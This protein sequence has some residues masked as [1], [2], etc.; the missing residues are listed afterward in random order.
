MLPWLT[1]RNALAVL[2]AILFLV[3]WNQGVALLYGMFALV[4]ATLVMAWI[5]PKLVLRDVHVRRSNPQKAHEGERIPRPELRP[6][7]SCHNC[8]ARHNIVPARSGRA[9][10]RSGRD[11]PVGRFSIPIGC[12]IRAYASRSRRDEIPRRLPSCACEPQ[13]LPTGIATP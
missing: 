12:G 1:L 10:V 13:C 5:T 6:D 7:V 9:F 4:L 8:D 11:D 2:A 3:A